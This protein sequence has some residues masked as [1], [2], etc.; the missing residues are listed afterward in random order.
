MR[1]IE[2]FIIELNNIKKNN[3]YK[4]VIVIDLSKNDDI[5]KIKTRFL[6]S[7]VNVEIL[8]LDDGEKYTDNLLQNE[9]IS[10]L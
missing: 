2:Q 6:D 5:D 1:N 4:Q 3:S 7:E 9:N 8:N 10:F